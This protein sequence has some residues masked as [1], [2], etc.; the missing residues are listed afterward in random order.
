MMN[1]MQPKLIP[2]PPP[3]PALTDRIVKLAVSV[4]ANGPN[5]ENYVRDKEFQNP[6]FAFLRGGLFS[7]YYEY[8]KSVEASKCKSL[9]FLY[10][11]FYFHIWISVAA[12]KANPGTSQLAPKIDIEQLRVQVA[13]LKKQIAESQYNVD[14]QRL[15]LENVD[16]VSFIYIFFKVYLS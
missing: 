12:S 4:V 13:A 2:P 7:E 9:Y 11:S 8:V 16:D 3:D 6:D 15:V 5:F 14:Q 1:P 10:M